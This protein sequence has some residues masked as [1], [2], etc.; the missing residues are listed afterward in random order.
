MLNEPALYLGLL[1]TGKLYGYLMGAQRDAERLRERLTQELYSLNPMPEQPSP[2]PETQ[3]PE[4]ALPSF[5]ERV[6]YENG[7][8]MQVHEQILAQIVYST[9]SPQ[10]TD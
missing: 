1:L 4:R 3:A 8:A 10:T 7:I 5:L 2:L 6:R 9:V